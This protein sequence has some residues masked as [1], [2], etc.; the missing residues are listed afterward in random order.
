MD[1]DRLIQPLGDGSFDTYNLVKLL[2]N[3][4]YE[5][6]FGLQCYNIKQDCEEALTK[7]MNTWNS[8]KIKYR[9]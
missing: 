2:K 6:K 7:S 8:Y 4:G 5:G 1:W 3:H 9:E